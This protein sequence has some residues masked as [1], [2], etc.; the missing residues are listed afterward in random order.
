MPM[1]QRIVHRHKREEVGAGVAYLL[2]GTD[3]Q[4]LVR[5]EGLEPS[6]DLRP[7]G[8]SYL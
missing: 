8:F 3:P 2:R 6:R 7:N 4:G 1:P 5:A